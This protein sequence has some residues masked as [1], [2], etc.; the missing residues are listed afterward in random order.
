M[1]TIL[2]GGPIRQNPQILS[3]Y[4]IS[5]KLL[6]TDGFD[7]QYFFVDDNESYLSSQLLQ[8]FAKYNN[9]T[10]VSGEQS[11]ISYQKT[12]H[13]D[14]HWNE[15]LIWKVAR[16]RNLLIEQCLKENYDGLFMVDSDIILSPP[17]LKHLIATKKDIISE[18]FWT[19]WR[20]NES[21][22]PQVWMY[23]EYDYAPSTLPEATRNK[24][25]SELMQKWQ[26]PGIYPVGGLGAC[27]YF[28]REALGKGVNYNRIPNLTFWGEDRH[29]SIRA[30]AL[31]I[32]LFVDTHYPALHLFNQQ[33]F[34]SFDN[35]ST[36][37]NDPEKQTLLLIIQVV[38]TFFTIS[39]ET[40]GTELNDL[41][42]P[43]HQTKHTQARIRSVKQT[44]ARGI[45][46][47]CLPFATKQLDDRTHQIDFIQVALT[48]NNS[49]THTNRVRVV[50][51]DDGLEI[52]LNK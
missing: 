5:L 16:Y 48:P 33:Q 32:P 29:F 38:I 23:N 21:A 18:I 35:L 52:Q 2:I 1:T 15:D 47:F 41:F 50:R 36:I 27:T 39:A 24:I 26:Q 51:F 8:G 30:G 3:A 4:L 49:K 10:I 14:P 44:Q 7:V 42:S 40:T 25:G 19:K 45:Q 6:E 46:M 12:T 13:S 34:T 31:G 28:S 11:E 9:A 20:E 22:M 37:Y 43:R 17:T